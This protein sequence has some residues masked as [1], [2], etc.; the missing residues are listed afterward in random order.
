[1]LAATATGAPQAAYEPGSGS[2]IMSYAGICSTDNLQMHSDPYFHSASLAQILSYITAGAGDSAASV[3]STGNSAPTVSAG[4]SFTI[5]MSTPFTLTATGSDWDGDPLTYCWEERDLGP[6]I[7]LQTPDNGS[8]PLFRSFDPTNSPAR[9]FPQMSDILN[10]TTTP[11]EMLPTTSRT[12]DFRVTARDN[13][14]DSGATAFSDTQVTVTTN[15]GPF[16]VISP[17]A[18]VTWSGGQTIT[19]SVAGTTNAPVSA[20]SVTILLSTDGG[21]SFPIVLASNVP[22][23]GAASVLLPMLNSPAA[24]IKVEADGNIFFAISPGNFSL[25][26]A[27]LPVFLPLQL[28]N[29]IVRLAWSA[30]TG[31]TYRVQYKPSLAATNWTDLAPDITATTSSASTTDT[32]GSAPQRFYRVLL[33]P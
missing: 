17:A 11:G 18:G 28:S 5:P 26:A 21:L 2:T 4:P 25:S 24:R 13:L 6:S 27:P 32:P 16:V 29:G 10:H 20:E 7:T 31:Q 8:S 14:A 23:T 12:M 30:L 3:T 9:T 15:A 33:L 22:N 19:W 1:M